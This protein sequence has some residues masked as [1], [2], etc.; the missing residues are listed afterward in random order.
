MRR[1][2]SS[3]RSPGRSVL[4][5]V[6]SR[7]VIRELEQLVDERVEQRLAQHGM[8][9][10]LTLADAAELL[11]C[12]PAALRQR[13]ARGVIPASEMSRRLYLKRSDI[14]EALERGR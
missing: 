13:V 1:L 14:N 5:H 10:W 4:E 8:S 12:T 11:G 9:E 3:S 6:F 2:R 7:D